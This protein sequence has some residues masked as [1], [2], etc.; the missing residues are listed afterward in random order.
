MDEREA[1]TEG[2]ELFDW[3]Q[4]RDYVGFF[5]RSVRRHKKLLIILAVIFGAAAYGALLVLP[6]TYRVETKV[7]AVR[8]QALAVRGDVGGVEPSRAASEI[9]L[10]HDNLTALVKQT[11]L[12]HTWYQ[13]R[14]PAKRFKDWLFEKLRGPE[15]DS[16]KMAWMVEMLERRLAVW[17]SPEG[18]VNISIDFPDPV[19]AYRLVEAAQQNFLEARHVAEISAIAESVSILQSHGANLRDDI[20]AAVESIRKLIAARGAGSSHRF[21]GTRLAGG[22][23]APAISRAAEPD[24][25]LTQLRVQIEAKQRT[26]TDLEDYRRHRLSEV[27]GRLA[28]QRAIL[29]PNHPTIVDLEQT[30]ASLASE[31]PQVAALRKELNTLQA[32][33]G[34]KSAARAGAD[35]AAAPPRAP[36]TGGLAAVPQIPSDIIRLN[37]GAAEERDPAMML[38]RG[39]LRDAMEKYATLRGQIQ[40][41]QIELE[42]AQAAFKYRYSVIVPPQMP[43][44]AI[45]PKK[46]VVLAAAVMAGLLMG[47]F[48]GVLGDI[49]KGRLIESW[50]VERMLGVPLLAEIEMPQLPGPDDR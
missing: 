16:E 1:Q 42:T 10:R 18:A 12:I 9:I 22:A 30:I 49:R 2:H 17:T 21:A 8:S 11:D 6:K 20:D 41:A 25:G 24:A 28:E 32:E 15:E 43:K 31:S 27:Q 34:L 50:Q 44:A 46:P 23:A 48:L 14:A 13:H 5:T 36:S 7:L 38:A 29:T 33:Y 40:Q 3:G 37:E 26:L 35:G 19:L 47:M 39:H 45:K 4:I